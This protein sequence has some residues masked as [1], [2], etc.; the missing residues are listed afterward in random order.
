MVS[1]HHQYGIQLLNKEMKDVNVA[2]TC[3]NMERSRAF[4]ASRIQFSSILKKEANN[5]NMVIICS[6][7][8]QCKSILTTVVL[9]I[10]SRRLTLVVRPFSAQ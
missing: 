3:S 1:S 2:M 10:E 6:T 7:M 4:I 8:Q 5:L 9:R